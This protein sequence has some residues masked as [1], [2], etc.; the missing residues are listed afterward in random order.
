MTDP[1][2]VVP[3]DAAGL[4]GKARALG[5][6]LQPAA[7]QLLLAYLD[8][9]LVLNEQINLTGIRDR[10]LAVVLHL[11]DSLA[12]A[13]L[14]LHPHYVLDLG[15]GNGFPGLGLAA[16]WP[17]ASVMLC[18]R[19]QKKI[20]AIDSCLLTARWRGIETLAADAAQAP[21]LHRD[22]RQAFD[23]VAARAL[24]E[25]EAVAQL[26]GPLCRPGGHLVL[27]LDADAAVPAELNG[28]QLQQRAQYDLP[29]PG[30]R[31]RV[32]ACYR[33]SGGR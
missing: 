23:L 11:L 2:S 20:R 31:H 16:L 22:L 12:A 3:T 15:S 14:S 5:A 25:P 26:A 9:L 18:D 27:W 21:A 6:E 10:E 30:A 32:L 19:T 17:N 13:R 33:R 24:G 8:A 4:V 7:A 1:S 29:A 28:F